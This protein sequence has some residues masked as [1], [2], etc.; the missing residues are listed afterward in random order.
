MERA[1]RA[2]IV[3]DVVEDEKLRLGSEICRIGEAGA[4]QISLGLFCHT[5]GIAFVGFA[6][7]WILDRANQAEG[8]LSVERINPGS[9]TVWDHEHITGVN[10]SP[11][12]NARAVKAQTIC[13]NIFAVFVERCGE[14]L[15]SSEQIGELEVDQFNSLFFDESG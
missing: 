3:S 7:D 1:V 6:G 4:L 8:R 5:T 10:H 15:P 9:L 14:V 2:I 12:T 11:A 13:K